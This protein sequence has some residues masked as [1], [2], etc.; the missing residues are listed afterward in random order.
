[1]ISSFLRIIYNNEFISQNN[2]LYIISVHFSEWLMVIISRNGY[3][4]Y[5][6][7]ELVGNGS[8]VASDSIWR[9]RRQLVCLLQLLHISINNDIFLPMLTRAAKYLIEECVCVCVYMCN[10]CILLLTQIFG[11]RLLVLILFQW[12]SLGSSPLIVAATKLACTCTHCYHGN[13]PYLP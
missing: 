10:A 1:M 12:L 5:R 8:S 3:D 11:L 6:F 13:Q 4:N 9:G 2:N 7:S